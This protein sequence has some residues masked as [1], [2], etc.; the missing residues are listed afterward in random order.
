MNSFRHDEFRELISDELNKTYRWAL[1]VVQRGKWIH[2][3]QT[4]SAARWWNVAITESGGFSFASVP[5]LPFLHAAGI[6][7]NRKWAK[8]T[9]RAFIVC[10]MLFRLL[11]ERIW[12]MNNISESKCYLEYCDWGGPE[13]HTFDPKFRVESTFRVINW[14]DRR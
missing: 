8:P 1:A 7:L 13:M 14:K 6:I 2:N 5:L 12:W 10:Y 3:R 9:P 11:P 4:Y